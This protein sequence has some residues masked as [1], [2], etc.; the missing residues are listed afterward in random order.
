MESKPDPI[1]VQKPINIPEPI[2]YPE[3][4][5]ELI[6]FE[7]EMKKI[8]EQKK[9]PENNAGMFPEEYKDLVCQAVK[10]TEEAPTVLTEEIKG[11]V[12]NEPHPPPTSNYA[13]EFLELLMNSNTQFETLKELLFK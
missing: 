2:K 11:I 7:Q 4:K 1:E 9:E 10:H 5:A 8:Q 13:D 3:P 6:N 12:N